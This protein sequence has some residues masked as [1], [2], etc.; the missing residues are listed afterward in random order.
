M[1]YKIATILS[2]IWIAQICAYSA[3]DSKI[4]TAGETISSIVGQDSTMAVYSDMPNIRITDYPE[5]IDMGTMTPAE[6][7]LFMDILDAVSTQIDRLPY[8]EDVNLY[9]ILTHLGMHYGSEERLNQFF[10]W[11]TSE[12]WLN[13]D[14]FAEY[15]RNKVLVD[16]RVDEMLSMLKEGSDRFKLFQIAAYI[17]ERIEY[18]E[19]FREPLDGLNG[20][21]VCSTYAMLFYKAASRLGIPTYICYGYA[22]GEYHAWNMVELDGETYFYDVTWF[23]SEVYDFT[24]L[25]NPDSWGRDYA[26]NDLWEGAENESV[27]SALDHTFINDCRSVLY[28]SDCG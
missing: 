27:T 13:L 3:L 17:A 9:R 5:S 18:D 2:L 16:A 11:T 10:V 24:Y 14:V 7:K 12:L 15:E 6:Q 8:G 20:N 1:K 22:C 23:D 19:S 25:H 26:L 21:G 4:S 28:G